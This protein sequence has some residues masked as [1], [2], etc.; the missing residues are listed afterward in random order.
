MKIRTTEWKKLE[1]HAEATKEHGKQ[2][3]SEN[4]RIIEW[5]SGSRQITEVKIIKR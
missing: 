2:K 3:I 4:G 1:T 5:L